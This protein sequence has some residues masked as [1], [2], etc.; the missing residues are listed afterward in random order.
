MTKYIGKDLDR[1]GCVLMKVL[2]SR[3]QHK[4]SVGLTGVPAVI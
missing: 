3:K 2:S 4:T 1:S